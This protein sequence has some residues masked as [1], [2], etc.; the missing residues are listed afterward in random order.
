MGV[1]EEAVSERVKGGRPG[2]LRAVL[3]AI[4]LGVMVA[5]LAYRLL[6]STS[7]SEEE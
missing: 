3:A 6:R 5:V 2:R 1:V 7:E 4:A